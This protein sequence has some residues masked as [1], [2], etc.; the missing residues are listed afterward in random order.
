[1]LLLGLCVFC[2]ASAVGQ[3]N[4]GTVMNSEVQMFE[5]PD[6][7]QEASRHEM[8]QER[9]LLERSSSLS[10]QGE[11]PLWEVM[12]EMPASPVTPLGDLARALRNE[13]TAARKAIIVWNN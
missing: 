8:K 9:D 7:P 1:M 4:G 3:T 6:H 10:A 13:H 2:T 11:R 12:Q 5:I